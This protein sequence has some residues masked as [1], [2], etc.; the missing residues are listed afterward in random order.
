MKR[1]MIIL[2][3]IWMSCAIAWSQTFHAII[4]ANTQNNTIGE[5][6]Q[7]DYDRM[8]IEFATI[9]SFIGYKLQKYYYQGTPNR[10]NA[11]NLNK[12]LNEIQCG[13]NDIVFFYYS[14]HG[15]RAANERTP[16]PEMVLKVNEPINVSD[17]YP[18]HNVYQQ[19]KAKHPRL[20]IVF[21]DLCNSTDE[22]FYRDYN[23]NRGATIRSVEICDIYKNL[24]LNVKG[25][26]IAASSKPGHTSGCARFNDG[27]H[28]GG[29]FTASFLQILG[30]IVSQGRMANWNDLFANTQQLCQRI[31]HVDDLGEKQTPIYSLS[32]L[33][34]AEPPIINTSHVPVQSQTASS[35]QE[36]EQ[37]NLAQA[38]SLIA[39]DG[40]D[41]LKRI[42]SI[43]NTLNRYFTNGQAKVEVVGRDSKTIVNTTTVSKYLN[44][45]SMAVNMEGVLV[46]A[47]QKGSGGKL[48]YIKI[49]EIRKQ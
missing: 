23:N 25:G 49:H 9:S 27:T 6:V 13:S 8:G 20:T 34:A 40:T 24:F 4:F 7:V 2:L 11:R 28:A 36:S 39:N 47:E 18:L 12:V 16:Y 30:E 46:V 48:S 44:Y 21:G 10:F 14:G 5:S 19:I 43:S 35:T 15:L 22:S 29:N 31:S 38:M 3:E 17:L 26:L 1:I 32:E 33:S 41:R 45:L 37:D 42:Q